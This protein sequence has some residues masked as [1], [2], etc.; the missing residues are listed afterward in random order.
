M[1]RAEVLSFVKSVRAHELEDAVM[2]Y[3]LDTIEQRIAC[4]IYDAIPGQHSTA[5]SAEEPLSVPA[6]Y[7]NIY[8][9]YLLSMIELTTGSAEGYKFMNGIFKEAF[10]EYAR[11]V[12]RLCG[13]PKGNKKGGESV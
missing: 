8:W 6:P 7:D 1:T 3:W 11:F 12:Q 13:S 5:S 2:L 4:E 10:G 9:T